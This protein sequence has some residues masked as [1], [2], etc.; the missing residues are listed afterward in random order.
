[1][2]WGAADDDSWWILSRCGECEVWTEVVANNAHA[3][4]YDLE[5]DRQLAVIMRAAQRLDAER[6]A[7]EARA[8]LLALN[9]DQVTAADFDV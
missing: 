4:L 3:A 2:E 9:A 8:F 5:L 7:E 6:M 1:M